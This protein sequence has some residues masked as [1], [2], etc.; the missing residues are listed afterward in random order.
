MPKLNIWQIKF[1]NQLTIKNETTDVDGVIKSLL[2]NVNRLM[3]GDQIHVSIKEY[4]PNNN[5]NG[6]NPGSG[7]GS[8]STPAPPKTDKER[9]R[10]WKE[11]IHKTKKRI[12]DIGD[13]LQET[14]NPF[15][16]LVLLDDPEIQYP[17][18]EDEEDNLM[19]INT[20]INY[21]RHTTIFEDVITE[22]MMQNKTDELNRQLDYR[23]KNS[24][25][26]ESQTQSDIDSESV[27]IYKEDF[28]MLSE[29]QHNEDSEECLALEL[30]TQDYLKLAKDVAT[31]FRLTGKETS[32]KHFER[33]VESVGVF[34]AIYALV[35]GLMKLSNFGLKERL[36]QRRIKDQRVRSQK[37]KLLKSLEDQ[38]LY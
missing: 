17:E 3:Q 27:L 24:I 38:S 19:T 23:V 12:R 21:T 4:V 2:F 7:S 22:A 16:L 9:A 18:D 6:A 28:K 13:E 5:T 8:G 31:N 14:K 32:A 37:A 26:G 15:R 34:E 35:R 29:M 30:L 11:Q 10:E 25:D 33:D 20:E 1:H 36:K